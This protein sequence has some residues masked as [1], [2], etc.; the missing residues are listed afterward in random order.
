MKFSKRHLRGLIK[1]EIQAVLNEYDEP[2]QWSKII[3]DR[4]VSA[5]IEGTF[6]FDPPQEKLDIL[7]AKIRNLLNDPELVS[8][9]DNIAGTR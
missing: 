4:A 5:L 2:E 7:E 6:R 3:T 9:L 8:M 1:E